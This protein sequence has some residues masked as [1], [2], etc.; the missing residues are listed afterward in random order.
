VLPAL[1]IAIAME[2]LAFGSLE[3]VPIDVGYAEGTS[4]WIKLLGWPGLIVHYPA[5]ILYDWIAPHFPFLVATYVIGCLD[6]L[7][8][9]F[10]IFLSWSIIRRRFISKL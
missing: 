9:I 1:L 6:C 4:E 10:L 3:T 2:W 5:L 7:A 8:I